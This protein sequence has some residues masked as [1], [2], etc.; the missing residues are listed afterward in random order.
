MKK[1]TI[2]ET[3]F[4]SLFLVFGLMAAS[5]TWVPHSKWLAL[6]TGLILAM[7]YFYAGYW[8]FGGGGL[9]AVVRIL[10]GLVF[11][12]NI[13]GCLFAI[14]NSRLW[15]IY[16]IIS[17]IGIVVTIIVSL[18]KYKSGSYKPILLRCIAHILILAL[19]F[20]YKVLSVC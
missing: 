3:I 10:S 11:S 13:L 6:I 17:L 8:L 5:N 19:I 4:L 7:P 15:L 14:L 20:G 18:I 16:C 12:I 2:I 1:A 9:P